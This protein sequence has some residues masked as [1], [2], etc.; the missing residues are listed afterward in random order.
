MSLVSLTKKPPVSRASEL[1]L[2][3]RDTV[4]G[5]TLEAREPFRIE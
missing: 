1:V 3:V 2:T 5:R 4:S